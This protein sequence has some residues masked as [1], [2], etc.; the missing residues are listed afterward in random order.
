MLIATSF[1]LAYFFPPQ[2]RERQG[3]IN[4]VKKAL[5]VGF[6]QQAMIFLMDMFFTE[7][8]KKC[9]KSFLEEKILLQVKFFFFNAQA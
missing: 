5:E 1:N 7:I 8:Q 6:L 9:S 4:M 3:T 2:L